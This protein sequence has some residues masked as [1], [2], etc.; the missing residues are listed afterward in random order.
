MYN[1]IISIP[2]MIIGILLCFVLSPMI[3]DGT[4]SVPQVFGIFAIAFGFI[5]MFASM[6]TSMHNANYQRQRFIELRSSQKCLTI[7]K[8]YKDKVVV[9]FKDILLEL[10]P[11]FELDL[12][13]K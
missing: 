2:S 6:I 10:Y 5:W 11:K 4:T 9:E 8:D 12:I 1:K 13:S 3:W 7:I